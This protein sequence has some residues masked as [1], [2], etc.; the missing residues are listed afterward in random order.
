MS[1]VDLTPS[2]KEVQEIFDSI[3]QKATKEYAEEIDILANMMQI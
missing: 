1:R 3:D 2:P